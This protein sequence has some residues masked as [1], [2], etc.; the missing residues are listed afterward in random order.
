[1]GSFMWVEAALPIIRSQV[2]PVFKD[3][4]QHL[5]LYLETFCGR[6]CTS[7]LGPVHSCDQIRALTL[8]VPRESQSP[9]WLAPISDHASLGPHSIQGDTQIAEG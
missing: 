1:M 5:D 3:Q 2:V 9:G 4:N 7:C 6:M 8:L